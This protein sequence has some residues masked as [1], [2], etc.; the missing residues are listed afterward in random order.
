M[1]YCKGFTLKVAGRKRWRGNQN[2]SVKRPQSEFRYEVTIFAL[3][4]CLWN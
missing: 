3:G 1:Q 2:K 4:G